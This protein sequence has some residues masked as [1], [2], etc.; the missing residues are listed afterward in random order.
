MRKALR[1]LDAWLK[2]ELKRS[3]TRQNR[4]VAQKLTL[5]SL[6]K[7]HDRGTMR[8][9]GDESVVDHFAVDSGVCCA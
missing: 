8:F 1:H 5:E 6:E 4:G 7:D 3:V 9:E 2:V